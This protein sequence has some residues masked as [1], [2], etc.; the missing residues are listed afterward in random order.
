[1][2]GGITHLVIANKIENKLRDGII[3]N[4]GLF[5][6][7]AIA[8]DAINQRENYVR[9]DKKH[10][11]LRDDITDVEFIKEENLSVFYKRVN[12]F[13]NNGIIN[14][15]DI[16]DLYKG[17][18]VH[19]LS[20]EMFLRTVR[21]NFIT[22]MDKLGIVPTD[23]LFR[24]ILLNELDKHDLILIRDNIKIE[25]IYNLLKITRMYDV[26]G[27]IRKKELDLSISWIHNMFLRNK[28]EESIKLQYILYEEIQNYIDK[29]VDEIIERL[30][31]G[32]T[33]IKLF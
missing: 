2:A 14:Y 23:I 21:P 26:E 30:S 17:Y 7:G 16:I 19:L 12:K 33:I 13:I 3:T 6:A 15:S 10:S 22:K 24:D 28:E 29:T 9:A 27:Y 31:T 5:Y 11:H 18:V 4:K 1:M 25:E 32:K 8:P 20:D